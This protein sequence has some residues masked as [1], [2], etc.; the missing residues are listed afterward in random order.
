MASASIQERFNK[1]EQVMR[2]RVAYRREGSR[3]VETTPW[4]AHLEDALLVQETIKKRGVDVALRLLDLQTNT[5]GVPTLTEWLPS[6]LERRATKT[7]PGT[8]AEYKRMAARTF[9]IRLGE[10]PMDQIT[11]DDVIGWIAW[12]MKQ[13]TERWQKKAITAAK[14]GTERPKE[15]FY[16]PKSIKNAHGLLSSMLSTAQAAGHINRNVAKGVDLPKVEVQEE[17]D[18][19]TRDEWLSFFAAMQDHY[20]PFIAF[21]LLTGA[22][23]GEA[24]AV[25]VRDFNL[26]TESVSIRQA[27]K[28]AEVGVELGSPKSSR[29]RRT[30]LLGSAIHDFA[31]L[32]E[33]KAAD[34]LVFTAI[35]GGQ[36]HAQRFRE[37]Q[38]QAA[39]VKSKISKGLT[40]HSLRHT[41]ASWALMEGVPAQVVQM[42]LG[43]ESLATTSKVYAHL[44]L[45]EQAQAVESIGWR[46]PVSATPQIGS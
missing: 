36:I 38:W 21:I 31:P 35:R 29:S 17:K 7:T 41:F 43:H 14:N 2:Y 3:K 39:V 20:K 25:R 37:R 8:L 24:T 27:W 46:M 10:I 6:H 15:E 33:G 44:L 1:T 13:T 16:L 9:L 34:D 30:I 19:F 23:M 45:S 5:R 28:K 40:P 42:R 18:I 22:R 12:Q 26:K 4:L 32:L 11:G